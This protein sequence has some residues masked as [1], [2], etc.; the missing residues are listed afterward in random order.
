MFQ[1]GRCGADGHGQMCFSVIC[2]VQMV[3][4]QMCFRVFRVVQMVIDRYVSCRWSLIDMFQCDR[5]G[6]DGEQTVGYI[7]SQ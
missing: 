5:G 1:C 2:V 6:A 3:H 4:G 7:Q